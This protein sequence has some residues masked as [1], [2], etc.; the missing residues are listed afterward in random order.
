M[1]DPNPAFSP[2]APRR[3]FWN[4]FRFRLRLWMLGVL[5]AVA[6]VALGVWR[7]R[8]RDAN[9]QR[10]WVSQQLREL[11]RRDP[12]RRQDA[13]DALGKAGVATDPRVAPALI[14]VLA[15]DPDVGVRR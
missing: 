3:R 7:A 4:W 12:L 10:A 15:D 14:A 9:P 13:A 6:A 11:R 5:V 8:V 1:S 2:A